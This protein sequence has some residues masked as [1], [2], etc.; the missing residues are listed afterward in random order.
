MSQNSPRWWGFGTL[1]WVWVLVWRF[2]H[3]TYFLVGTR[4]LYQ[5]RLF[6]ILTCYSFRRSFAKRTCLDTS[7]Y[8]LRAAL[9]GARVPGFCREFGE[10]H[11]PHEDHQRKRPSRCQHPHPQQL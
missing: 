2:T 11:G 9:T 3:S 7:I 10:E 8:L 5:K 6:L 1:I 4:G